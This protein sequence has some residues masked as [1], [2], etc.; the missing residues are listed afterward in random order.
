MALS[1]ELRAGIG[2][3]AGLISGLLGM[4]C[5]LGELCFLLPDMLVTRDALPVY[6]EYVGLFRGILAA[7][8]FATIALGVL[9]VAAASMCA[10]L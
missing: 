10:H 3:R 4:L 9:G 8:I 7:S 6:V 2:K 5:V 1:P